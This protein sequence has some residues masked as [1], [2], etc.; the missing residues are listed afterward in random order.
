MTEAASW[1]WV[2]YYRIDLCKGQRKTEDSTLTLTT[3]LS[4]N[5]PALCFNQFFR[6]RQ[7]DTAAAV[8]A[9]PG[10]IYP[11]K[12]AENKGE[13]FLRDANAGIFD[14]NLN[15][16]S[17]SHYRYPHLPPFWRIPQGIAQ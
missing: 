14:R 10:V 8:L 3:T 7:S 11:V 13:V 17:L 6:N 12:P 2:F 4:P 9:R 1:L 5:L 16:T 15:V